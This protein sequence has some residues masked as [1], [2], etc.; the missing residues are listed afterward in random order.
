MNEELELFT[1][2][3]EFAS[4]EQ[5]L[6]A[7]Q[8]FDTIINKFPKSDL[9]DDAIYNI[10]LCYFNMHQLDVAITHFNKIIEEYPEATIHS[11]NKIEEG[12]TAAKALLGIFNCYFIQNKM[13]EA[14]KIVDK[15]SI[16]DNNSFIII[17][18]TKHSFKEIAEE[19]LNSINN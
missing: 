16:Y 13:D 19:T 3:I 18:N 6:D 17:D 8:E 10:G 15:L 12:K 11:P 7:V 5:Y 2:A 14:K 4:N 9:V 1:K